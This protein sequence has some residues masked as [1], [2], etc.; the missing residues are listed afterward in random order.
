MAPA[1]VPSLP[2][3]QLALDEQDAVEVKTQVNV[4]AGR[5]D[6]LVG[7]GLRAAVQPDPDAGGVAFHGAL[8][9]HSVATGEQ[10]DAMLDRLGARED[11]I[12]F[13][14][15]DSRWLAFRRIVPP[16]DVDTAS[17]LGEAFRG[18]L[19]ESL[20]ALEEADSDGIL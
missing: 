14:I 8:A 4:A 6:V 1:S 5:V 11:D 16:E 20:D 15:V 13:A 17:R 9:I 18:F 19:V 10:K 7:E 3:L 2:W 12:E